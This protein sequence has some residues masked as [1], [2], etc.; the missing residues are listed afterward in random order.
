MTAIEALLD[1]LIDYAGIYPPAS[2]GLETAVRNYLCYR[3]GPRAQV[4]GRFIIDADRLLE[5]RTAAGAALAELPLSICVSP[6]T[7]LDLL[8]RTISVDVQAV[9][10]E[11]KGAEP[12]QIADLAARLPRGSAVYVEVPME[13]QAQAAFDAASAAGVRIKLRMGGVIASAFPSAASVIAMLRLLVDRHLAFK[14]TAGLHHPLQSRRP[15]TYAPDSPVG[16]M[17]GFVNLFAAT[18]LI[19]CGGNEEEACALLNESDPAAWQVSADSIACRSFRVTTQQIR[20]LRQELFLS[21][22]SCSFEE[23]IA[24]LEALGWL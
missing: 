15:F 5:L 14:A 12:A 10:F 18:A 13:L 9:G 23:P 6:A 4:L 20:E 3:R 7:D 17:H 19:Y 11:I 22:G 2:L 1:G 8:L 21:F 24:D 16:M